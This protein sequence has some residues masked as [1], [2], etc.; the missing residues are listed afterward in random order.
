MFIK[1]W[2]LVTMELFESFQDPNKMRGLLQDHLPEFSNGNLTISSCEIDYLLLKKSFKEDFQH[3]SSLGVGYILNVTEPSTQRHGQLKLYG[4]AYLG[5]R[6]ERIFNNLPPVS[7]ATP[8]F[9]E[10]LVHLPD[11]G[12]IIWA[13]PNDPKLLHLPSLLDLKKV[14]EYLPFSNFF[15][16]DLRSSK[17][18]KVLSATVVRYKPELRCTIRYDL[19]WETRPTPKPFAIY[20]KTFSDEQSK[21]IY[22]RA[23]YFEEQSLNGSGKFIVA[24]PLGLHEGMNT[25]WQDAVS[26]RSLLESINQTNF[27]DLLTAVAQG[28]AH[29]HKSHL[30]ISRKMSHQDRLA[31]ARKRLAKIYQALPDRQDSLQSFLVRLEEWATD[32]PPSPKTLIH[33][34]FHMEQLLISDGKIV[35]FDFDDLAL[36]DPL[37]DVAD[38]IAQLHFYE[39]DPEF[40]KH[41]SI[42]FWRSYADHVDWDVSP[43]RLDWHMRIQFIRKACRE[44][45]Q[46][47]PRTTNRMEHFLTLAREGA[48]GEIHCSDELSLAN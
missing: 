19:E 11:L 42:A 23:E 35:L 36:G 4:K 46:Q 24:K 26:G 5:G 21:A 22:E 32:F 18:L 7:L 15:V 34:D 30:A 16:S 43:D 45:L 47:Q 28:L 39:Y 37:Q 10:P 14:Q 6:S 27:H 3:K 48:F 33:G 1:I 8:L 12:M 41:M 9:G 2:Q 13:F 17:N 44:F 40:I 31:E 38:F 20:A 25:V 29:F